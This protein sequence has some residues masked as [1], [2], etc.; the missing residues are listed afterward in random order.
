V[1]HREVEFTYKKTGQKFKVTQRNDIDPNYVVTLKD[2]RQV[3]NRE[4]MLE[5]KS[6]RTNSGGRVLLHHIGQDANGPLVEVIKDSHNP[7]LH[8]QYGINKPH[9]ANPV[10]RSKFDPIKEEYWKTYGETFN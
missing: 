3:T 5:G 10:V 4:L 9:P 7:L 2:G 1:F 8:K 6:P